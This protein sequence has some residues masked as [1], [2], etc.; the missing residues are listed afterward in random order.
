[1]L[2]C[3]AGYVKSHFRLI[4]FILF[5]MVFEIK[6]AQI[7][8]L[9]LSFKIINLNGWTSWLN[10]L[11]RLPPIG[12]S[13]TGVLMWL[14]PSLR[15]REAC[16]SPCAMMLALIYIERLRHRNPEYLQNISSSDLFLIS[17]VRTAK[18][19]GHPITGPGYFWARCGCPSRLRS[20]SLAV[21]VET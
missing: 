15:H 9:T 3:Y 10:D 6:E 18:V 4:L 19:K 7:K 16:I 2:K 5:F 21:Y 11:G 20:Q 8:L 13:S 14:N 17:M 12:R 1:M